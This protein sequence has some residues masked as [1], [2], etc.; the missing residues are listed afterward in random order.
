M[1]HSS[2]AKKRMRQNQKVRLRNR[3]VKTFLKTRLKKLGAAMVTGSTEEARKEFVLTE[4]ALDKAARRRVIHPNRAA[5]KKSRMAR[6]LN[7]LAGQ[8]PQA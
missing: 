1:P 2:S 6:K 7:R 8:A 4:R 5:R 3:A